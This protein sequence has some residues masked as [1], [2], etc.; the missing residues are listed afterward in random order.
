MK[1]LCL[2]IFQWLETPLQLEL[3]I[4]SLTDTMLRSVSSKISQISFI[5]CCAMLS[6][7]H[8]CIHFR[9]SGTRCLGCTFLLSL[10]GALEMKVHLF[11]TQ[12]LDLICEPN[13]LQV[14][15]PLHFSYTYIQGAKVN[16]QCL[17]ICSY[18]SKNQTSRP[19]KFI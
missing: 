18:A 5:L 17:E 1:N 15:L 6:Q 8:T 4:E 2:T 14:P 11:C 19:Q 12:F 3:V 10:F 16:L 13:F 9:G 7:R